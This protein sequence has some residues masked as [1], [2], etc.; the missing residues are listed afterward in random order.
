[1]K[2]PISSEPTVKPS[3]ASPR[4]KAVLQ[5]LLGAVHGAAVIAE[6]KAAD[7]RHRDDGADK[8]IFARAGLASVMILPLPR[9]GCLF[10]SGNSR[11]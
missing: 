5:A 1:M 8:P 4:S 7:R 11:S 6:Q 10:V 2:Q 9:A 3:P